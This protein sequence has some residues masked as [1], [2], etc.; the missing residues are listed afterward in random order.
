MPNHAYSP[1]DA[2]GV[3]AQEP[4]PSCGSEDT[5]SYLYHE[6]FSELECRHCGYNSEHDELGAL[7]RYRGDLL[8][9][10]NLP[11]IPIKKIKA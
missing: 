5:I 2:E 6:G 1:Y 11:P 8:E 9:H 3:E 10:N 7:M 4:C